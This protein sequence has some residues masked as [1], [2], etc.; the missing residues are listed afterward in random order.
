MSLN[1][2]KIFFFFS[3]GLFIIAFI[4]FLISRGGSGY[5]GNSGK[6][7]IAETG[8]IGNM[9]N[10]DKWTRCFRYSDGS[11]FFKDLI[12]RNG[13]RTLSELKDTLFKEINGAPERAV[14]IAGDLFYA[15]DG[16]TVFAD[17]GIYKG[18]SWRSVDGLK[19]ITQE[20]PVFYI[21]DGCKPR[22]DIENWYGI[23]VYRAILKISD[24]FWLMTMY[25]NMEGDTL[26]PENRDA[27][28]ELEYMMR[29]I[30]V[31]STDEG[32]TWYYLSSVAIPAAGEPVGEGFVEPAITKLNDGRLLCIMRSGHHFPLYSSWSCDT[33]KTWTPPLYTGFDRGCDPCLITLNNG[34]VALSWGRRFPEGWSKITPEGDKGL[35]VYP[36]EGYTNLS[37]SSDGGYTWETDRIIRNSGSCYSTIFEVEP[38]IIFMQSDQWYCRIKVNSGKTKKD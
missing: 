18:K 37:I 11:I 8:T 24:D 15:L 22:K 38:D 19:T 10:G 4:L 26:V 29:T 3:L 14:L 30:I 5:E 16:P 25:G 34:R 33:G 1:S 35:F 27:K 6:T 2:S 9:D 36:G 31:K 21:P 7:S 32:K 28:K 20:E 13:G 23:Y 12:S 17:Q